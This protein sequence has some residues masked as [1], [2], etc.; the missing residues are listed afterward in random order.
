MGEWSAGWA[1]RCFRDAMRTPRRKRKKEKR[2]N[3]RYKKG[4]SQKKPERDADPGRIKLNYG[5]KPIAVEI[6]RMRQHWTGRPKIGKTV[7]ANHAGCYFLECE[8]GHDHIEHAGEPIRDWTHFK[9]VCREV[10]LDKRDDKFPFDKVCVDTLAL[11]YKM[12]CTYICKKYKI[13][14]ESDLA[15]GKGYALIENEFRDAIIPLSNA[16]IGVIFISHSEDKELKDDNGEKYVR[17]VAKIPTGCKRV[18]DGL[19]DLLLFFD[20]TLDEETKKQKRVIHTAPSQYH[21]AGIRYPENWTRRIPR[22]I[23]MSWEALVNAWNA[24]RPDDY[25]PGT[26]GRPTP[27]PTEPPQNPTPP[28]E[29]P[30]DPPP[31]QKPPPQQRQ[32]QP[33][34][35][36]QG[37]EEPPHPADAP[38]G[39]RRTGTKLGG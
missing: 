15:S 17:H 6:D 2:V 28:T 11:A 22:M 14:H 35:Q 31:Q 7:N 1:E 20:V 9:Q 16:G 37:P 19:V 25:V 23:P 5:A 30:K 36:Q 34:P 4:D 18:I 3:E 26:P 39:Q 32:Q 12:A 13:M 24:G 8:P 29:P 33:P 21:D 27:A 10:I 38:E